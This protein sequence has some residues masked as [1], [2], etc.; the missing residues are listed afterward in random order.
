MKE[1][2]VKAA[3][4]SCS[5]KEGTNWKGTCPNMSMLWRWSNERDIPTVFFPVWNTAF[6]GQ[7]ICSVEHKQAYKRKCYKSLQKYFL[8]SRKSIKA[9]EQK[10]N[11]KFSKL[12]CLLYKEHILKIIYSKKLL[13]FFFAIANPIE[14]FDYINYIS[15]FDKKKKN[16]LTLNRIYS[17][18]NTCVLD[19][20]DIEK[21]VCTHQ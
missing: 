13:L 1:F 19:I 3:I 14:S 11:F 7:H 8:T 10:I 2:I 16:I 6:P 9:K 17:P 20:T 12:P 21:A 15:L 4:L 18:Q 5:N